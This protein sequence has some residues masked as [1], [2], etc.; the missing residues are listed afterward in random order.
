[1]PGKCITYAIFAVNVQAESPVRSQ[2]ELR[3]IFVEL[4]KVYDRVLRKEVYQSLRQAGV[5][6]K[7]VCVWGK[8]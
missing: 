3:Y 8:T 4:E 1:M 5:N 2:K 6:G 7:Y